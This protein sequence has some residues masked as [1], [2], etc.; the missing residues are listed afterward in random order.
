M[1]VSYIYYIVSNW[2]YIVYSLGADTRLCMVVVREVGAE[3]VRGV[4]LGG[5]TA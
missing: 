4:G 3:M 1:I 5:M 2:Q